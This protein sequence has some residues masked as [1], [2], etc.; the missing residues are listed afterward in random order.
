MSSES[1]DNRRRN[2]AILILIIIII[3]LLYFLIRNFGNIENRGPLIP[4][5]NV[6]IFEIGCGCCQSQESD[7]EVFKEAN[8][9]N[10]SKSKSGDFIVFDNYKIWDNKRLRIFSNPAY[11]YQ[12]VIAPGSSNSYVFMIRN[13]NDFDIVLDIN[14]VEENEYDVN[15]QYKLR[16]KGN[17]LIGS[18]NKYMSLNGSKTI[19]KIY[20]PA[21]S[22]KSYILDWKWIDSTNDTEIGFDLN[23]NYTLSIN[24]GANEV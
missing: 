21:K 11:E 8:D 9:I 18:E 22:Q 24:V 3:L 1:N 17:Y 2:I 12:S 4:T 15:M 5:G 10:K 6:D 14:F 7:K 16:N 23:S 19:S 13:N 20:L